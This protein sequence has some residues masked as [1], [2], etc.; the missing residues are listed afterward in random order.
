MSS[1]LSLL[2]PRNDVVF[3]LLF[4]RNPDML[5][6]MLEAVLA[7]HIASF[8]VLNPELPGDLSSD[9][10][11]VLDVRV[12][13]AN[14]ARV[15][16]EMQVRVTPELRARL[17]YYAARDYTQQLSRGGA[18]E[19]LT[20][21]VLAVWLD[22]PLKPHTPCFTASSSSVSAAPASFSATNWRYTCYSYATGVWRRPDSGPASRWR[23]S[24]GLDSSRLKLL[25]SSP[26]SLWKT[27]P[28]LKL[29]TPSNTCRKI[30]KQLGSPANV[31]TRP[32]S[33]N[34]ASP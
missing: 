34:S 5:G 13:L 28:C 26:H 27:P 10:N 9:K 16:V 17:V 11:I 4:T 22:Q 24:A 21:T 32:S 33:T 18:F 6:A 12:L 23:F 19:A 30:P 31:K 1:R 25:N 15:D 29:L 3:K 2:N 8:T 14:G 20:P 7:E